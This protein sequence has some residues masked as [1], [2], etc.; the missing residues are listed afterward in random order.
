MLSGRRDGLEY[1]KGKKFGI[2][3]VVQIAVE[4]SNA[5]WQAAFRSDA[6]PLEVVRVMFP[7]RYPTTSLLS[8][9][10]KPR[11][12]QNPSYKLEAFYICRFLFSFPVTGRDS[13]ASARDESLTLA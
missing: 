4:M 2:P 5:R 7:G 9:A 8:V 13:D 10:S 11:G 12:L 1:W 6:P 3:E